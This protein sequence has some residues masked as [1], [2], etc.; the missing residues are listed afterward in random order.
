MPMQ[1][2]DDRYAPI[3]SEIG[4]LECQ[5]NPA[6]DAYVRWTEPIQSARG[7]RLHRD[8]IQGDF[9]SRLGRLL[10]LTSVEHRRSLFLPTRSNWTAYFDNGW[11][12]TDVFS[13]VSELC[14]KIGCRGVRAVSVPHTMRK[15]AAG[16]RGRYGA[17]MLEIYAADLIGCSFLNI[18]RSISAAN[19][20]GRWRFDANGEVLDFE[21]VEHYTARQIRYR[22][23]PDL[24]NQ[25][26]L[27]LG[28]HFF[29][30]AF[31]DVAQPS[32]L[33]SK[34]GPH[35]AAMTEYSLD[36]ARADF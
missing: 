12:G 9:P 27:K 8:E 29:S 3:T 16:H 35:A 13:A 26:L 21:E 11:Q 22:F 24:L 10:P 30:P 4:F 25:Y 17:T 5:A 20:G 7:V 23:T 28:I 31:Y 32:Y 14:Q 18:R 19:D 15:T 1:L 36:E 2:F 33:I 6:A 34:E